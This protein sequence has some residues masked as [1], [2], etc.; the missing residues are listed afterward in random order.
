MSPRPVR[1]IPKPVPEPDR[2][3]ARLLHSVWLSTERIREELK[4]AG[5]CGSVTSLKAIHVEGML[6]ANLASDLLDK[7]QKGAA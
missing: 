7:V 6:I 5:E 3:N 2:E 4:H 1:P